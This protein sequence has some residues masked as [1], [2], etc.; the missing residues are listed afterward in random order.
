MHRV[1]NSY[2]PKIYSTTFDLWMVIIIKKTK[3]LRDRPSHASRLTATNSAFHRRPTNLDFRIWVVTSLSEAD[4]W[5]RAYAF[6][7]LSCGI[8]SMRSFGKNKMQNLWIKT[9]SL[10]ARNIKH[11][12]NLV[13]SWCFWHQ[14]SK[15]IKRTSI[16]NN[17]LKSLNYRNITQF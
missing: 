8:K 10:T 7:S 13:C 6:S 17:N 11:Y 9:Q 4:N 2:T 1:I 5:M 15:T 14:D 3:T 16:Q 12:D